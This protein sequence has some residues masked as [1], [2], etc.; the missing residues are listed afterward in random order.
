MT[1]LW[2]RDTP[3]LVVLAI[4]LATATLWGALV[5]SAAGNEIPMPQETGWNHRNYR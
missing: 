1:N 2:I 3:L 4:L 5:L